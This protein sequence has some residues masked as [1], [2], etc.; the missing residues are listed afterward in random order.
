[1]A[2]MLRSGRVPLASLRLLRDDVSS[3]TI[4]WLAYKR[5]YCA[6]SREHARCRTPLPPPPS[7]SR[8]RSRPPSSSA[9]RSSTR[10]YNTFSC[11]LSSKPCRSFA[12]A[13]APVAAVVPTHRRHFCLFSGHK[14]VLGE[15]LT[16]PHLFPD[17]PRRWLRRNSGRTAGDPPQ[18]PH[19]KSEFL[20]RV[21][22]VN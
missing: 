10:A 9:T 17:H 14:S 12:G 3:P 7:S 1:M 13:A 20:S 4:C 2:C 21:F 15:S 11:H 18:G 8:L 5:L 6:S 22:C 19:C 16:L